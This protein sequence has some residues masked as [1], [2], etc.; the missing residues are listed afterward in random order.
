MKIAAVVVNV[1]FW[2]LFCTV[3]VTDGPPTGADILISLV[4]FVMPILNVL[5]IRFL[6]SPGRGMR[7]V[8]LVANIAWLALICWLIGSRYP[9]HPQEEGLLLYVAVMALTPVVSAV[10]LYIDLKKE[11]AA[12]A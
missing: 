12:V 10:A 5:V 8:A 9:S 3:M 6:P 11:K 7:L 4:A 1:F 2:L